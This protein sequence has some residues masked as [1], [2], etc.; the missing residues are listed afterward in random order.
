MIAL[1][2]VVST[3]LTDWGA[4]LFGRCSAISH[5]LSA[6]SHQQKQNACG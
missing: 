4:V 3:S 6:I 2:R 1:Q 5:Q